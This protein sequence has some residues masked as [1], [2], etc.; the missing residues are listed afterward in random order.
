MHP[1]N[2]TTA[3]R[4]AYAW[5][6]VANFCRYFSGFAISLLLARL[7][8]PSAYGLVGMVTVVISFFTIFQDCSISQ[9]IIYFRQDDR[10]DSYFTLSVLS[11]VLFGLLAWLSAPLVAWFYHDPR[12]IPLLQ[13]LALTIPLSSLRAVAQAV[14]SRELRFRDIAIAETTTSVACGIVAVILAWCGFGVWSLIGNLLLLTISQAVVFSFYV[15][16]RFTWRLDRDHV[17]RVVGWS[18]PLIGANVLWQAYDNSDYAVV[19]RMLGSEPLGWYTFAFR[20]ATLINQKIAS[21]INRVSLP[22]FSAMHDDMPRLVEHWLSITRKLAL[23]NFSLLAALF[24]NAHD[25]I[26]FTVGE[27]WAPA[28]MPLQ[29]LC[30]V[31]AIRTILP[32]VP[33]VLSACGKTAIVFRY[34]LLSCITLPLAFIV[35][36]HFAGLKGVGIAWCVLFP[37]NAL[38]LVSRAVRVTGT[39]LRRYLGNLQF[40]F[41]V[42]LLCLL[43]MLPFSLLQINHLLRMALRSAAGLICYLACLWNHPETRS[44]LN[45]VLGWIRQRAGRLR[46]H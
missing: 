7:L 46:A 30:V 39:S 44:A 21:V 19:G 24:A 26:L 29:F 8:P 40:P 32:L 10:L 23:V 12:V 42:A 16:P 9:A 38:F 31:G 4:S 14:L 20:L 11:S 27:K 17:R 25:L 5:T 37:F 18:A 33:N 22:S 28:A 36:C 35:G 2:L 34:N 41:I 3:I 45:S 13:V 1:K 6:A 15:R 43:V